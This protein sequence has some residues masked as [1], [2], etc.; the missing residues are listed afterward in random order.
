MVV[1]WQDVVA[2]EAVAWL[3]VSFCSRARLA[4]P[5][6]QASDRTLR[7]ICRHRSLTT[8]FLNMDRQRPL[9]YFEHV[10][11]PVN[12]FALLYDAELQADVWSR[13]GAARSGI[14]APLGLVL[15]IFADRPRPDLG[16]K[17]D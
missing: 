7:N 3:L 17:G 5:S 11:P 4:M 1:T 14:Q 8:L 12:W 15:T 2:L 13:P 10:P 9:C 6:Q 16:L